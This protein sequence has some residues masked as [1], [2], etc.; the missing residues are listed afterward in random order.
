ML[1]KIHGIIHFLHGINLHHGIE[2]TKNLMSNIEF[3]KLNCWVLRA[4]SSAFVFKLIL[5]L[6][7]YW[8]EIYY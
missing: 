3:S 2:N 8:N 6:S 4:G 1:R 7:S 5:L